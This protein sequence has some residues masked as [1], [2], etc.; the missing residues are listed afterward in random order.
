MTYQSCT[1]FISL[2]AKQILTDAYL[3][4]LISLDVLS[5]ESAKKVTVL[6]CYSVCLAQEAVVL[7]GSFNMTQP[8]LL[9][10]AAWGHWL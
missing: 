1:L 6:T 4:S 3:P 5:T 7:K 9:P 8:E 10:E 2:A